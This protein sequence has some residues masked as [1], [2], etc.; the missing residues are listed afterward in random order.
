MSRE[1]STKFNFI[2]RIMDERKANNQYRSLRPVAPVSEVEVAIGEKVLINFSSNDYLGLSKHPLLKERSREWTETYGNGATASRLICGTFDCI[3]K[4]EHKLAYLKSAESSLILNSGFQ[5]NMTVIPVLADKQSLILSDELNHNSLIQGCIL[6]RCEK[7]CF[8]HNDTEHLRQLLEENQHKG[9][10][11]TLIITETVF[12]MDGDQCDLNTLSQLADE[13]N[14]LLIVDEA[15]ATG[16]LG[17]NGMG[18]ACGNKAD[19]VIGTFGKGCGSFGS[20]ITCS[21][22]VRDYLVNYCTGFVF[23]TG[24]PP[25]VLGAID[26]ALDLIP[27]MEAERLELQKKADFIRQSLLKLN[28][29]TGDSTTQIIPVIIGDEQKT[30]EVA[31]WLEQNNK[32]ATAIRPPTVPAG[33]SRI[34]LALSICHTWEQINQLVN[35]FIQFAHETVAA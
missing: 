11:R 9:Y 7:I 21:Q 16:V 8:R 25:S 6:A 22:Q 29:K 35:L 28:L 5:T 10:S 15:H 31:A 12:S 33:Q 4:L 24:L 18:M 23:T 13:F 19:I 3:E 14:A 26:A 1:E 27:G 34:R 20:Y 2:T 30:L 32:L 17:Q